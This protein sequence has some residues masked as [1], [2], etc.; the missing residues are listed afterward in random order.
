MIDLFFFL[1][2]TFY[3][4]QTSKKKKQQGPRGRL[5]NKKNKNKAARSKSRSR[6]PGGSRSK[7]PP[8]T[9]KSKKTGK[10]QKSNRVVGQY[11]TLRLVTILTY[12]LTPK[13]PLIHTS[14]TYSRWN[15]NVSKINIF[16]LKMKVKSCP[17]RKNI[18]NFCMREAFLGKYFF[19]S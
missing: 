9:R 2:L 19:S 10:K 13:T 15:I 16:G 11:I 12:Y 18:L 1:N 8:K 5:N 14:F 4:L 17:N 3:S 6:S 7:S